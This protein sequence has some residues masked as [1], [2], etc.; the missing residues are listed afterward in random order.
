VVVTNPKGRVIFN[1]TRDLKTTTFTQ[2]LRL[3]HGVVA[4]ATFRRR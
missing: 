1:E 2:L 4:K 3:G